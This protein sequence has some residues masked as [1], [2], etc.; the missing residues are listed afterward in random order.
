MSLSDQPTTA[1]GAW[2]T[3]GHLVDTV[4]AV[5]LRLVEDNSQHRASPIR[6]THLLDPTEE[7]PTSPETLLLASGIDLATS[8][9][10]QLVRDAADRG[11]SGVV[12]K[13]RG[14]HL[15]DL[16]ETAA[17]CSIPLLVA[18]D[19][20]SWRRLDGL[21]LSA[22]GT[23]GLNGQAITGSGDDMFALANA[24][25]AIVGGSVAIEDLDRR[26][27]AYS[28]LPGH[29]LDELRRQGILDR[30][31]PAMDRH[32]KQYGAVLEAPGVV[33]FTGKE[34]GTPRAAVA[35]RAGSQPLG[36]IWAI[37]SPSGLD[38]AGEQALADAGRL[39]ALHL[40]RRKDATELGI[41]ERQEALRAAL[42]GRMPAHDLE[43][44]L[45]LPARAH[46]ALMGFSLNHG[47]GGAAAVAQ[48]GDALSRYFAVFHT[49]AAMTT[50]TRAVYVLVSRDGAEA[51]MRL[52]KGAVA[53]L[54]AGVRDGL[55]V[56]VSDV[57]S[58]PDE[59][60]AL[61]RSV[62]DVLRAVASRT[63]VGQVVAVRDVRAQ[64]LLL[65]VADTVNRTPEL[66]HPGVREM[67]AHDQQHRTEFASSVLAWLEATGDV[68]AAASSLGIH[69]N[70][71]RYRLRRAA[72]LFDLLL[73]DS[74]TRLS[75]WIQIRA[76]SRETA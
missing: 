68:A 66:L 21:I 74:D 56:G 39:A 46:I 69:P 49:D 12:V 20:V 5:A 7:L 40:L 71:L 15:D 29:P 11:F 52:A 35:I 55:L 8:V 51:A 2:T 76:Q 47:A 59:L 33:R 61:R 65:H 27:L 43:F 37:E 75:V 54:S 50:T 22:L 73:E 26:V 32:L 67:L 63:A 23:R 36:T 17:D 60:P 34:V 48:L 58:S 19:E 13:R 10:S 3:L 62:D 24:T 4:G 72:Q 16:S 25:A 30:R 14:A 57:A 44:R 9:A 53:S 45:G 38:A 70:T 18:A 42:D 6:A 41:Q 64:I 28:S 31:V 1:P